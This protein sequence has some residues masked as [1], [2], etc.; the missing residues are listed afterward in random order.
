MK[1]SNCSHE[2]TSD[3][4]FC[5]NCGQPFEQTC[6]NCGKPVATNARFCKNC[7]LELGGATPAARKLSHLQQTAPRTLQEKVLTARKKMEGERKLVTV[8]F[9]DIVGSTALAEKLD[10]EEWG[11]IVSDTHQ[12]VS[13]AVYRY[14]GTI[15]QL[16]G[17]GVLAFF[18]APITHEDDP[19]RAVNA[20]LDLLGMID[21]SGRELKAKYRLEHL[22]MRVGLNTG[23]V[24]VGNIGTDMHMEYLAV[25]DTVNLAARLQSS[26]EA[27]TVIISES[28]ARAAR[29]AFDLES[30]GV[31]VLKGKSEPVRAFRVIGRKD[32]VESGRGIEGLQSPLVGRDREL[33]ILMAKIEEL[34]QGRGQIVSVIGEAGLGKSRLIAELRK[35]LTQ[36]RDEDTRVQWFEA[37]SLSFETATPYAPF[38]NLFHSLF[39]I[40]PDET[41]PKKYAKIKNRVN[42]L[43]PERGGEVAPF[44]AAMM[45]IAVQG[46]DSE[47]IQYLLPPNLRSRVFQSVLELA[48]ALAARG[49]LILVFEDLHWADSTSLDLIGQ[50]LS[51]TDRAPILLL[52]LFR[53]QQQE[54]Y[55]RFHEAAG[56]DFPHRYTPIALEPL[57]ESS[58]RTLIANLL[59]I[60]DL[61]EKVRAL[62]LK[63]A[64]GNPFYVEE[65]IRSLLDARLII[66]RE[67]HWRATREIENIALPDTLAG[68]I[69]ARLDRLDDESK[70]I[71]QTAAVIGREFQFL[72]LADV[73]G[74]GAQVEA[75][76][77]TLQQRELV[78]EKT[79]QPEIVYLFKHTL[80]QETAYGSVLLSRRREL[81]RRV[82]QCI[83]RMDPAR[84]NDI[85]RHF[86]QAQDEARALPYLL[87][88][89][90]RAARAYATPEA[91]QYYAQ[92]LQA[93]PKADNLELARRAYEGLGGALT[94]AN[95]LAGAVKNYEAMLDLAE[96]RQDIPMQVSAMNKLASVVALR[97]GQFPKA[98]ERLTHAERLAREVKDRAGLAEMFLIRC[99][100]CSSIADF[101]GA[102]NYVSQIVALA[103]ESNDKAQM[104]YGLGH[105]ANTLV[106]MTRYDEAFPIMQESLQLSREVGNL[107]HE[108]ENLAMIAPAYYVRNGDLNTAYRMA[109][110][111]TGIAVRIG[112]TLS[113]IFGAWAKGEIARMR[114][115]YRRAMEGY[116]Q[117]LEAA[118]PMQGFMPW[119]IVLSLGGL[120][121][122][123]IEISEKLSDRAAEYHT[124]ALALLSSPMG[125]P[126]GGSA[127]ADIGFC[128]MAVGNLEKAGEVFQ[129]GLTA[130]TIMGQL[131]KP[132]YLVGSALVALHQR[133][134]ESAEKHLEQARA[135]AEERGMKHL[136]PEIA[137]ATAQLEIALGNPERA[138]EEYVRAETQAMEM[139]MRPATWQARAGA[140]LILSAQG[141]T[142]QAEEKQMTARAMIQEIAEQITDQRLCDLFTA[143]AISKL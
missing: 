111:G 133:D 127:W 112:A 122:T 10:P 5:E 54:P 46:Q 102:V 18:G 30:R 104:A 1:C 25:G 4:I 34:R 121:A 120:G 110:Q 37:R 125:V 36:S 134:F 38:I 103:R 22:D 79:R 56:S 8:L 115:E 117:S 14:E 68:V 47:V 80:T 90:D 87:E 7:G 70:H 6:P 53:P 126:G 95:D 73:Y 138:L 44:L 100:M 78:R 19:V 107:E 69:A 106:L 61:P 2:N 109:E 81:H 52:A 27:N 129:K 60:E 31:L 12:L 137:L 58:A 98:E 35:S 124:E 50:M 21:E 93:L 83:E 11:E 43:L 116:Y 123:Y 85:A 139:Q 118:R 130:P 40:L 28:T 88:A 131:Y 66:H 135:F 33:K 23:L 42:D 89:G 72:V 92:A 141:K 41:D 15:A 76:I 140:A 143:S 3:S 94:L 20:A 51:L 91:I 16:L 65:V 86:W 24:V 114:G 128:A 99:Q 59:Q 71:A 82:A 105:I 84:A 26:A 74:S 62:I 17:D 75:S 39:G 48:G 63:K 55:W 136:Y 32:V 132:R 97:M 77:G 108:A 101:D 67:G 9:T 29:H 64:E 119:L 45:G 96:A 113:A 142:A 13:Q 49:P 57:D